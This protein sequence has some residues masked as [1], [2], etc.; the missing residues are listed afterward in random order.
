MMATTLKV[1]MALPVLV[2][3]SQ[4]GTKRSLPDPGSPNLLVFYRGDW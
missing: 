2:L 1:G 4:A 3:Q